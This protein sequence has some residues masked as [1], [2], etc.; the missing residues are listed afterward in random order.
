MMDIKERIE[1]AIIKLEAEVEYFENQIKE[2]DNK[3][4]VVR[5]QLDEQY[6]NKFM[7]LRQPR[8]YNYEPNGDW[9]EEI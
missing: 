2:I 5:Q 8:N 1:L 9:I 7:L 6:I 3:L 4:T